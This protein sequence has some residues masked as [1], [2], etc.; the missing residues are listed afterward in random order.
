MSGEN[1]PRSPEGDGLR[2]LFISDC[3][4]PDD[5]NCPHDQGF[6]LIARLE[7]RCRTYR[8]EREAERDAKDA[9]QTRLNAMTEQLTTARTHIVFLQGEVDR[10]R[11]EKQG[12]QRAKEGA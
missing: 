11:V 2:D 12:L 4:C 10:L 3:A 9:L 7:E 1:H 8:A 5:G 6:E